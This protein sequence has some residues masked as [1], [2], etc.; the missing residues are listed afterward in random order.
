MKWAKYDKPYVFKRKGNEAQA[1]FNA[2]VDEALAQAVSDIANIS[3]VLIESP[4][5]HRAHYSL[6]KGQAIIEEWQKLIRLANRSEHSLMMVDEY[7]ADNL[8]DSSEDEKKIAKAERAAEWKVGKRHKKPTVEAAVAKPR[9]VL[10]RFATFVVPPA[11][12]PS[13]AQPP[14]FGSF[15]QAPGSSTRG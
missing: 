9:R 3:P 7:T 12:G 15:L 13:F 8:V 1:L 2:K 5:I 14:T 11:V 4:A 6:Q 10:A